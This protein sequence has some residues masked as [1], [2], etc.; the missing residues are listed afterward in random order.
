MNDLPHGVYYVT[1]DGS[2]LHRLDSSGD[3]PAPRL[4]ADV[5]EAAVALALIFVAKDRL[6]RA[7]HI[8]ATPKPKPNS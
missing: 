6:Q 8:A 4:A 5:P 1:R 2:Q 3:D 7:Q